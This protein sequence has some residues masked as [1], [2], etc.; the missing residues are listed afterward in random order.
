MSKPGAKQKVFVGIDVA[1][2]KRKRLPICVCE[3]EEGGIRPLPLR[4]GY[5]KPPSG[6]GNKAAL[7]AAVRQEYANA[8]SK[9]LKDLQKDLNLQVIKIAID[10]PSNYCDSSKDR[11]GSERAL[12]IAGISCF[13]T[14]TEA[15]FQQ[16]IR[17]AKS[18]L[19]NGGS[20]S[21]I[22]NANQIW[23]LVGFS[24]FDQ[25]RKDGFDCI[26]TYP[27]AIVHAMKCSEKHKST[28][29]GYSAQLIQAALA[30]SFPTPESLQIALNTMGYGSQDDKLDAFLTAWVA[31]IPQSCQKVYGTMPNDSIV[32]PD[33]DKVIEQQGSKTKT[34]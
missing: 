33:I 11:R 16:K 4:H 12:D 14:P 26:E 32:I 7:E 15:Q 17:E 28:D 23:M 22:P 27:Q 20:E 34:S 5:L 29:E 2:A 13:A 24:L 9:W 19:E 10:A 25:L 30:T 6:M 3:A 1:I 31:G 8:V 21:T 18:H